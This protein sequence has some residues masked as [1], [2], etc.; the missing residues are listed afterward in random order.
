[1]RTESM[2][3]NRRRWFAPNQPQ[4]RQGVERGI[5]QSSPRYAG[6][7]IV[8]EGAAADPAP[9]PRPHRPAVRRRPRR[10]RESSGHT[11]RLQPPKG[12]RHPRPQPTSQTQGIR[13]VRVADQYDHRSRHRQRRRTDPRHQ[14]HRAGRGQQRIRLRNLEQPTRPD[15]QHRPHP[16]RPP[17][18]R[19]SRARDGARHRTRVRRSDTPQQRLAHADRRPHGFGS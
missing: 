12:R 19:A 6:Q 14:L 2:D 7:P 5:V 4:D 10:H 3:V 15:R 11:R 17:D 13:V 9:P 18:R 1:M 8:R 16:L